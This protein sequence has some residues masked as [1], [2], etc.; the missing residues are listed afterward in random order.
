MKRPAYQSIQVIRWAHVSAKSLGVSKSK[1][2]YCL[3][4][5]SQGTYVGKV[6]AKDKS[7]NELMCLKLNFTI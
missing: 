7:G 3:S 5:Y 6:V 2:T 4:L 1:L